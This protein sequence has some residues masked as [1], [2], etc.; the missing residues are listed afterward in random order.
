METIGTTPFGQRSMTLAMLS[1]Q[2]AGRDLDDEK[3]TDKW[4]LYRAVCEARPKLGVTDRALAL[5]NALLSFYPHTELSVQNGLVVFPSNAQLSVRAHGMAEQTIR[6]HLAVLVEAG[7]IS[8]KDSANGKRFARR[9]SSGDIDEAYGF[10]LAPLL[11]RAEEIEAMAA[12]IAQERVDLQR[13]RERIT[14]C[15]RDIAKL[16]GVAVEEAIEGDWPMFL[17]Q[18][19]AIVERFPRQWN[20]AAAEASLE[21]LEHLRQRIVNHLELMMNSENMSGNAHDSERHTQNSKSDSKSVSEP[22]YEKATGENPVRE[23]RGVAPEIKSFP[24]GMVLQACPEITAYGPA[25]RI[26]TWRELMSAAVVVRSMLGVSPSAYQE[27]CEVMGP[28]NAATVVACILERAG[29]INS[30]GGYLR[31]LT[32]K[33]REGEFGLG[34]MLM[35]LMRT[36]VGTLRKTG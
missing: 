2:V 33:A 10:S 34:P 17:E 12:V 5:L 28:E 13:L 9:G 30:A 26:E 24:L 16:I 6:R 27:A 15:R 4:K 36:H 22:R 14:I 3:S 35:A 1:H 18:F 7:L 31:S 25:G 20:K 19:R 32:T 21:A 29:H 11:A 23:E 8:R